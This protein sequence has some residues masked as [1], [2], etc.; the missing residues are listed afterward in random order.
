MKK[1]YA[2]VLALSVIL[3]LSGC[4]AAKLSEVYSEEEVISRAKEVVE[5]INVSD[6]SAVNAEV[7]EDL[8]GALNTEKLQEAIGAFVNDAGTFVEF[9]TIVTTGQK[10]KSTGEDYAVAVLVCKYENANIIYTIAMDQN[11]DIV[12]L[13]VK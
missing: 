6:F 5:L 9:S 3:L 8:Q 4:S 1:I 7:R 13:Y 10:S 12:G 11:M 2:I